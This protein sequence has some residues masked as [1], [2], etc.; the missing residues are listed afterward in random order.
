MIDYQKYWK[1]LHV[2]F[3]FTTNNNETIHFGLQVSDR[4]KVFPFTASMPKFYQKAQVV[5]KPL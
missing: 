2:N 4:Q 5:R 3:F 1:H